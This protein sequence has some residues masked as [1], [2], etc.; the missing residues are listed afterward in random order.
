VKYIGQ[1]LVVI[2]EA[3]TAILRSGDVVDPDFEDYL[4]EFHS[5]FLI[6][7]GDGPY[8][9][10]NPSIFDEIVDAQEQVPEKEDPNKLIIIEL[11][12]LTESIHVLT[13]KV[14]ELAVR[15][16]IIE[17]AQHQPKE[18][19]VVSFWKSLEIEFFF[20]DERSF[21]VEKNSHI[22]SLGR[23]FRFSPDGKT[24]SYGLVSK[25]GRAELQTTVEFVGSPLSKE[26]KYLE[27]GDFSLLIPCVDIIRKEQ[28]FSYKW[29]GPKSRLVDI[30]FYLDIDC[31][32]PEICG[33]EVF[34]SGKPLSIDSPTINLGKREK[35]SG[36]NINSEHNLIS[37][38]DEL[39][40]DFVGDEWNFQSVK[41][42]LSF[43]RE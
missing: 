7:N 26:T 20:I 11:Q 21:Y 33:A 35:T 24:W 15:V 5:D 8:S 4:K 32:I 16:A 29:R 6:E 40:I 27:L 14:E 3:A 38:G 30:Y 42:G 36:V 18:E 31:S 23:I 17:K 13:N 25:I 2:L 37:F 19:K 12:S 1:P 34:I 43:V 22:F 39:T 10:E 9:Q 28:L 41:V